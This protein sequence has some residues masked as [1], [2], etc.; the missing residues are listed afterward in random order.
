MSGEEV[1]KKGG[2]IPITD[3]PWGKGA[4]VKWASPSAPTVQSQERE[5]KETQKWIDSLPSQ[6]RDDVKKA[7][8][9]GDMKKADSII[10]Q[11]NA[12]IG[13][14]YAHLSETIKASIK[15]REGIKGTS[16][17]APEFGTPE[18]V[19]WYYNNPNGPGYEASGPKVKVLGSGDVLVGGIKTGTITK[20]L[21]DEYKGWTATELV[22][23]RVIDGT[24]Y[25]GPYSDVKGGVYTPPPKE[26][27]Q[28]Y[29]EEK[30]ESAKKKQEQ[31]V[32]AEHYREQVNKVEAPPDR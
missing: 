21:S 24:Y 9:K 8:D 14:I 26:V 5:K 20:V 32:L 16:A 27:Q 30:Y 7:Y 13:G 6:I 17:N 4:G 18:Y 29:A 25:P 15:A 19:E 11:Y 28:R 23:G 10:D 22:N 12:K 31:E 2:E 3:T 1:L